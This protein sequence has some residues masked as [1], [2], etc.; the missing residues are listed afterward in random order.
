MPFILFGHPK[1][2]N[3]D[4]LELKM[5][6]PMRYVHL[7]NEQNK[8]S[9]NKPADTDRIYYSELTEWFT[10]NAFRSFSVKYVVEGA[11]TYRCGQKEYKVEKD[12]FLLTSKQPFV[13]AYFESRQPVKSICIDICP[14][15]IAETFSVL[16]HKEEYNLDNYMTGYFEC[17]YF[18]EQVYNTERTRL[19]MQLKQLSNALKNAVFYENLVN[20]EWFLR[21][22]EEIV[23][24]EKQNCNSLNNIVS[25]KVSTR[26][27]IYERLLTGKEFIHAHYLQNPEIAEVARHCNLSVYHFFRSFKQAFEISPYQYMLQLRLQH[28]FELLKTGIY[29]VTDIASICSFPDVFTFSKAFKKQ[30]GLSPNYYMRSILESTLSVKL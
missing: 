27:E 28:A 29:S 19:G 11:I 8:L 5:V 15:S 25:R 20:E 2:L 23:L 7:I 26:K 4:N 24:Q 1:P 14:S 9:L 30:Y 18:F 6:L 22:T 16:H 21:L 3:V 10:N 13:K 12:H 17:P